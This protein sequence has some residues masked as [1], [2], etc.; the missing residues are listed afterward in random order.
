MWIYLYFSIRINIKVLFYEE[1]VFLQIFQVSFALYGKTEKIYCAVLILIQ[2]N[3]YSF[4]VFI[5]SVMED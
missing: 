5:L 3:F 2:E 4:E 1:T